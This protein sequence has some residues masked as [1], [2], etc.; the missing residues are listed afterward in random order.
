[1]KTQLG[2]SP[3]GQNEMLGLANAFTGG[4]MDTL[5]NR[6]N[7]CFVS[8]SEDLPKLRAIHTIFDIK[9]PS[10]CYRS[11][12]DK[13]CFHHLTVAFH[14]SLCCE[15]DVQESIFMSLSFRFLLMVSLN[16]RRE[17]HLFL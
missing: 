4:D 5:V 13:D 6:M 9:E 17:R 7:E 2:N 8:I 12:S 1:M 14:L 15:S 16:R 11:Q 10:S 3:G